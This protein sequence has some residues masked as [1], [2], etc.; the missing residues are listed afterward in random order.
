MHTA[1]IALTSCET[2]DIVA[3]SRKNPLEAWRRLQKRYD[4]TTGGRTQLFA[5]DHFSWTVL[6]SGTPSGDRTLGVLRASLREENEKQVGRRD[7][8]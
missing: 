7:Q 5:H 8:T 1:L 2:N 6:S 4:P 3:N